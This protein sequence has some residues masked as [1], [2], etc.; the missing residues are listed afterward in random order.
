LPKIV[1]KI[2]FEKICWHGCEIFYHKSQG[3]KP[4]TSWGA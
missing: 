2:F 1:S 3:R 4:W